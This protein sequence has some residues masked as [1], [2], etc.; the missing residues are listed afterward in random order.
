MTSEGDLQGSP[1]YPTTW[2]KM[3]HHSPFYPQ[4]ILQFKTILDL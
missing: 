1:F 2:G 4:Y 3:G